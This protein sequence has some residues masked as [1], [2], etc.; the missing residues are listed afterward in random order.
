VCVATGEHVPRTPVEINDWNEGVLEYLLRANDKLPRSTRSGD[1]NDIPNDR[2]DH[3]LEYYEPEVTRSDDRGCQ[4]YQGG[5][6]GD[7]AGR[8]A[9][10]LEDGS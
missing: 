2:D 5:N 1:P 7:S 8:G 6:I 4:S 10:T 3:D 9:Q